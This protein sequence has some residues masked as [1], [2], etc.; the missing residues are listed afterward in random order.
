[1]YG[2]YGEYRLELNHQMKGDDFVD[3]TNIV[4]A[5]NIQTFRK[6]AGFTQEEL[7]EKLGVSFQAVS[8]W[9]NAKCA[10]DVMLLPVLSD[11]F[12]CYIDELFGREVKKEIHYDYCGV[13]PWEDDEKVRKF[14]AKGHR[15]LEV[16]IV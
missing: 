3:S 2:F 1:M 5:A 12:G 13:L 9:E 8:K 4:L 15:I 11:L 6:K 14:T 10:P 7:A 16:E